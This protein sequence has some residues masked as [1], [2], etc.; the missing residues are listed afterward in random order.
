M[1]V[2][3]R[4]IVASQSDDGTIGCDHGALSKSTTLSAYRCLE[5]NLCSYEH[6]V[7]NA[8]YA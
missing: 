5:L 6:A 4:S 1:V 7:R 2:G 3:L 8:R